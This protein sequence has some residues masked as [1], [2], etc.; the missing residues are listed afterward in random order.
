MWNDGRV[1]YLVN[2]SKNAIGEHLIGGFEYY[3][4]TNPCLQPKMVYNQFGDRD[5]IHQTTKLKP[6]PNIPRLW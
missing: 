2:W 1:K 4:E 6:P 3:M 5:V